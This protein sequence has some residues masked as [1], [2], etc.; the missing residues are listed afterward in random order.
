MTQQIMVAVKDGIAREPSGVQH[1]VVRGRTLADARHPLVIAYPHEW[2]PIE[3]HLPYG[4]PDEAV[5]VDHVFDIDKLRNHNEHLTAA[6]KQAE[7]E[8][9]GYL[10]QLEAV[11]E[12]LAEHGYEAPA[13][14][15][16]GWLAR[17]VEQALAEPRAAAPVDDSVPDPKPALAPAVEKPAAPPPARPRK[18]AAPAAV[19]RAD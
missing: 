17:L 13:E 9:A 11:A 7:A 1:R 15:A 18:K 12:V 2:Q 8:A 16:P 14:P 10:S 3:I 19:K 5:D 4:E 6:H